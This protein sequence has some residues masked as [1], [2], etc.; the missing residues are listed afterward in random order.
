[1]QDVIFHVK[2]AKNIVLKQHTV[3]WKSVHFYAYI[4]LVFSKWGSPIL[5][6]DSWEKHGGLPHENSKQ[7]N[8]ILG[9]N[10]IMPW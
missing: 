4:P 7:Q 3:H 6:Q 5:L 9:T 8:Y 2:L 10:S 1:M